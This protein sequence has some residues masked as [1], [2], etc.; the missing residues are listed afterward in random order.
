MKNLFTIQEPSQP[1]FGK[2]KKKRKKKKKERKEKCSTSLSTI[3][4]KAQ[5]MPSIFI[6]PIADL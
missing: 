1:T 2:K 6:V 4:P 3:Y 5:I